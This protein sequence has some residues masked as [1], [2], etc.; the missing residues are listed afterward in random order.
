MSWFI[1]VVTCWCIVC[2]FYLARMPSI[3]G[4]LGGAPPAGA[5][6]SLGDPFEIEL[7]TTG[8]VIASSGLWL[9]MVVGS[10]L[11]YWWVQSSRY[12]GAPLFL[13]RAPSGGGRDGNGRGSVMWTGSFRHVEDWEA[14]DASWGAS[15]LDSINEN[16][17]AQH[18]SN[19]SLSTAMTGEG[20]G[21]GAG[22]GAGSGAASGGGRR[23]GNGNGPSDSVVAAAA[24]AH[25][26][27]DGGDGDPSRFPDEHG[28]GNGNARALPRAGAFHGANALDVSADGIAPVLV[29]PA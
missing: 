24:A 26:V 1:G 5:T 10:V 2:A 4:L 28:R 13:P 23:G 11:W 16:A 29:C 6:P 25:L 18:T 20:A 7:A 8:A 9:L 14:M 27:G 19:G 12:G 15:Q 22:A 3:T 21:G 17:L